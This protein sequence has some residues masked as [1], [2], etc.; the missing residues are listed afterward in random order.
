MKFTLKERL[1]LI[2]Y[3]LKYRVII[4]SRARKETLVNI[5]RNPWTPEEYEEF[6]KWL[7]REYGNC[8][9]AEEY[10]VNHANEVSMDKKDYKFLKNGKNEAKHYY[11]YRIL[12]AKYFGNR[13][14]ENGSGLVWR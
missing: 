2:K 14:T 1:K 8:V 13:F 9:S 6:Q 11:K 10:V 3:Q 5:W 12:F 4:L 7:K